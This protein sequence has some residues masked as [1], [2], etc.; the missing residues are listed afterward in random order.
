MGSEQISQRRF[1]DVFLVSCVVILGSF[2]A[3]WEHRLLSVAHYSFADKG[4]LIDGITNFFL[5][6]KWIS[7]VPLASF[8]LAYFALWLKNRS[9]KTH[10]CITLFIILQVFVFSGIAIS[11]LLP[12]FPYIATL[13]RSP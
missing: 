10:Y 12:F 5:S 8:L 11:L 3:A 1:E 7:W 4:T 2:L 6:Y 13:N 9:D